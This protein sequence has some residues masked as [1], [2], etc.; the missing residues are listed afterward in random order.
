M[1]LEFVRKYLN[2]NLIICISVLAVLINLSGGLVQTFSEYA[3]SSSKMIEI[4]LINS[5]M[6]DS[7][8]GTLAWDDGNKMIELDQIELLKKRYED[9]QISYSSEIPAILKC[10]NKK[11]DVRAVLC[12]SS[13]Y[14]MFGISVIEGSFFQEKDEQYGLNRIIISDKLSVALFSGYDTIGNRIELFDQIYMIVGVYNTDESILTGINSDGY[15]RIY[16]PYKSITDYHEVPIQCI[17]L[18]GEALENESFRTEKLEQHLT[19]ILNTRYLPYRITDFYTKSRVLSQISI[20]ILFIIFLAAFFLLIKAVYRY[21]KKNVYVLLKSA[22]NSSFPEAVKSNAGSV[23]KIAAVVIGLFFGMILIFKF[24]VPDLYIDQKLIPYDN[25]FDFRFYAEQIKK[26][27]ILGNINRTYGL[28][29]MEY[30][31]L[32]A[33]KLNLFILMI[34]LVFFLFSICYLKLLI[35]SGIKANELARIFII[36]LAVGNIL[37]IIISY[38]VS[39]AVSITI[40]PFAAIFMF[41]I[42]YA[43]NVTV[44]RLCFTDAIPV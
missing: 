12:D 37:S 25:I 14:G 24:A 27:V 42:C 13:S 19:D 1:N 8:A 16:M 36:S 43:K 44:Q 40:I 31:F 39:L 35:A 21:V 18:K 2:R 10:Y 5:E 28:S 20:I 7:R 9:C 15:E 4:N 6:N 41:Y 3:G 11:Y 26:A 32:A 23:L 17:K 34:F 30:C 29:Q 22:S 33:M 38:I